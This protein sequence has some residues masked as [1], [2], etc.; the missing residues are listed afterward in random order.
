MRL[1]IIA[2]QNLWGKAPQP[3]RAPGHTI[4]G[5]LKAGIHIT[6]VT[7]HPGN[8][9]YD[10]LGVQVIRCGPLMV[11]THRS[12]NALINLIA[13]PL[14]AM[15]IFFRHRLRFD[16]IYG[17]EVSAA[18]ASKLISLISRKPLVLRFQGTVLY[19]LLNLSWFSKKKLFH[20]DHWM[21]MRL[22]CALIVMTNDG[23]SGDLVLRRL[24]PHTPH[25]FLRNGVVQ[26]CHVLDRQEARRILNMESNAF[27]FLTVSRLV[28][29]KRVDRAI[30]LI[31]SLAAQG[32]GAQLIV[33]G[34]GPERENLTSL[35]S[36]LGVKQRVRF[37]GEVSQNQ[38]FQ[39]YQSCD[40]FL[41]LFDLSNVGNPLFEAMMS[42]CAIITLNNGTTHEIVQS[43]VNGILI[44][45]NDP[46]TLHQAAVE[47]I[48]DS[49]LLASLRQGAIDFSSRNL[50]TW[51]QRIRGEIS[52]LKEVCK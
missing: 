21:A 45:P 2:T 27:V 35:A 10:R 28:S 20:L 18:F 46:T 29:W 40:V 38:I 36:K 16:L 23:T 6:L 34:G 14:M 50:L 31:G 32:F 12:L 13:F 17:H 37:V 52:A 1:C 9:Q 42:G 47:L 43:R 19:P 8:F 25:I 44:E 4:L 11:S 3:E 51:E 41:S 48:L 5:F 26:P 49:K 24:N 39:Y 15:A 7:S 22:P 33:V 30:Q